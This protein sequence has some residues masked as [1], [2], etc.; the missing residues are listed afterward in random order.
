MDSI[1]NATKKKQIGNTIHGDS[2]PMLLLMVL[3]SGDHQSRL[4]SRLAT[5]DWPRATGQ[6]SDANGKFVNRIAVI[7]QI[8]ETSLKVQRPLNQQSFGKKNIILGGIYNQQ[9]QGTIRL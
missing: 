9:F 3:K 4:V 7:F 1:G 2:M 6:K 5:S 8:V